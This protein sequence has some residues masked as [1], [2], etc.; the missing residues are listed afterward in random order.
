MTLANL[1]LVVD[2]RL[3]SCLDLLA[4]PVFAC[5]LKTYEYCLYKND[6]QSEHDFTS[7]PALCY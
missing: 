3:S 2:P 4:R 7:R 1:H 6:L 5:D